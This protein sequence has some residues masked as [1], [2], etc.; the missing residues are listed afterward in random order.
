MEMI[1]MEKEHKEMENCTFAPEV[2]D[3]GNRRNLD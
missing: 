1:R 3:Y 2:N